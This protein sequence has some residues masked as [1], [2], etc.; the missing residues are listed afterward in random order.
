MLVLLLAGLPLRA[1][2]R[3]EWRETAIASFDEV[4]QTIHDTY[5]DPGF[6]GVDWEAVRREL[7]PQAVAAASHDGV[8]RVIRQ[9]L[10]RLGQ[11]HLVLL[12]PGSGA[13]VRGDARVAVDLRL[14]DDGFV[15][16]RVEPGS[17]AETAG[18]TPG[19]VVRAVDGEP[20]SVW[21]E[22][23]EGPDERSR[24]ADAYF[25]AS[26]A[27]TGV[28]GSQATLQVRDGTGDKTIV[29]ARERERGQSVRFG[30]LPALVVRVEASEKTTP[31][32][33]QAGVIAFNV[34][35]PVAT[36]RIDEA[37]ERFRG[38]DGL[39]IDLRGNLGG[40]VE[41]M[42]GVA[43][44][45]I[46]EPVSLG[47][48]HTRQADLELRVNPRRSTPDGRRVAP[49]DGPVAI[50]VD[51]VTASA[52]ECFAGSLQSLGRARVFGR[53]TMGQALPAATRRLP[54]GDILMHVLGDFVT[55]TGVRVEGRGVVPDEIVP[56]SIEALRAGHDPD[57]DAALAWIDREVGREE[58]AP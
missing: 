38:A 11:S 17:A 22:S 2:S 52:S 13:R 36:G 54:S 46:D 26:A 47:L 34:W 10:G 19:Q 44:H 24:E 16:V 14:G 41:M 30:N 31:G 58:R 33:R 48:M 6:G 56:L 50:L 20:A 23:A 28:E 21:R 43:G 4:W 5:P 37:V 39:V 45:V 53:T 40:L 27:L 32:R 49:F 12:S 29:A 25:R 7:R 15:I 35:M 51:E 8:R 42:R 3:Q 9:M 18:L 1:G 57:L 55:P